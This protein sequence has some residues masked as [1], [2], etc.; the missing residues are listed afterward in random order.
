MSETKKTT[1]NDKTMSIVAYLGLIGIVVVLAT[2]A[3]QKNE[4]VKFHLNQSIT[5]AVCAVISVVPF[6]GWIAGIGVFVL[7]I[8]CFI[9]AING[10]KKVAPIVG[11]FNLIK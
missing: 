10:E 1:D 2:G 5:L 9:A 11:N 3:H 4:D 7:W 8:V 6:V